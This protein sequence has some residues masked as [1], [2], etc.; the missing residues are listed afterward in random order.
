MRLL[1]SRV[2]VLGALVLSIAVSGCET[3][4]DEVADEAEAGGCAVGV[5]PE[6]VSDEEAEELAVCE[7]DRELR[8]TCLAENTSNVCSIT[9]EEAA[10][11][12]ECV[13]AGAD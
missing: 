6:D 1:R 10:L 7:G 2:S 13:K 4:C 12:D 5:L 8:A 3:I 9:E 11:V